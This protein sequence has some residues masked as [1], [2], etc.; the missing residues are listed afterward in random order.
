MKPG[1]LFTFGCSFTKYTY[2]TWADIVGR[3]WPYYENWGKPGSGN[4]YI[5]NS[6]MECFQRNQLTEQDFIMIMWSGIARIDYYQ[7]G[8]WRVEINRFPDKDNTDFINCPDGYEILSYALISAAHEILD[9]KNIAYKSMSW[10]KYDDQSTAG[11]LYK[12]NLERIQFIDF[13]RNETHYN[14]LNSLFFKNR[15]EKLYQDLA[16]PDWPSLESILKKEYQTSSPYIEQEIQH[17]IKVYEQDRYVE[18]SSKNHVDTHPRPLDHLDAVN[19]FFPDIVIDIETKKW[20]ND[21]DTKLST[22]E[23]F[24]FVSPGPICRL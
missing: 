11:K 10:S 18:M 2:P 17:F 4:Q 21:I 5:F 15:L 14:P 16:G 3:S 23:F 6:L 8:E 1:R 19:K 13:K 12:K 20:I 22:G 24:D 9:N 7:F